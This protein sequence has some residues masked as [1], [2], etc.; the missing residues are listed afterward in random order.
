MIAQGHGVPTMNPLPKHRR[1]TWSE[2]FWWSPLLIL[3]FVIIIPFYLLA[4]AEH[5]WRKWHGLKPYKEK[6]HARRI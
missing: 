4:G 6:E 5:Y 1:A 2:L 3:G